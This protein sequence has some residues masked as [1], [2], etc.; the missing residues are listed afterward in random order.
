[1][2]KVMSAAVALSL[3]GS[4]AFAGG[5]VVVVDE[6][7]PVVVTERTSSTGGVLVPVL[8]GAAVLC[9]VACGSDS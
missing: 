4:A 2:K 7:E 6:V 5:P 3:V 9:A 1:M 8:I